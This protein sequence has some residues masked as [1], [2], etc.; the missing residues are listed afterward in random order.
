MSGLRHQQ[1]ISLLLE[2]RASL[3]EQDELAQAARMDPELLVL[4][5]Q[6]MLLDEV[7]SQLAAPERSLPAFIDGLHE[8]Q[9]IATEPDAFMLRLRVALAAQEE[10][11]IEH[12]PLL[13]RT[14]A[15]AIAATLLIGASCL[16]LSWMHERAG[17]M[18]PYLAT[19]SELASATSADPSIASKAFR[20]AGGITQ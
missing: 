2:G 14:G 15:L 10:S 7:L 1:L 3:P 18:A 9:R 6:Q 8:Q 16:L 12:H 4:L 13:A 19:Y 17:S 20:D 11:P 5:R